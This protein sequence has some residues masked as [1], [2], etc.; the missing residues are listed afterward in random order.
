MQ[1]LIKYIMVA[2]FAW[3]F[4]DKFNKYEEFFKKI[5]VNKKIIIFCKLQ[6]KKYL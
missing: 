4:Q 1:I 3:I 2:I 5:D 6:I